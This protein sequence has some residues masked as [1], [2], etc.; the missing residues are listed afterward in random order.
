LL[1]FVSYAFCFPPTNFATDPL[2]SLALAI[3][4]KVFFHPPAQTGEH[5]T[6]ERIGVLRPPVMDPFT[7]AARFHQPCA[8][9][10][11][12]VTGHFWLHHPQCIG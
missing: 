5:V 2:A 3:H 9:Q 4:A 8:L 11:S 7:I 12:Q 1:S 10:M 6:H